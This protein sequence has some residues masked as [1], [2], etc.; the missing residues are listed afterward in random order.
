MES[1]HLIFFLCAQSL[2]FTTDYRSTVAWYEYITGTISR[3]NL[4]QFDFNLEWKGVQFLIHFNIGWILLQRCICEYSI[5]CSLKCLQF[6]KAFMN[7]WIFSCAVTDEIIQ[8]LW[9]VIAIQSST[10]ICFTKWKKSRKKE[11][12]HKAPPTQFKYYK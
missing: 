8:V 9:H 10:N 4:D 7:P 2:D 12:E 11:L 6:S 1:R 5:F 3:I